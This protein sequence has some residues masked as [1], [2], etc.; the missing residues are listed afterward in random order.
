MLPLLLKA[1][2]ATGP[3]I[4]APDLSLATVPVGYFG[5]SA[6]HRDQANIEMLAKMRLVMIEKWEGRCWQDCLAQGPGS[7]PCQPACN[8]EADIIDT[9]KRIKAVNPRTAT[10]MYLNTLLAF[11]FYSLIG[12]YEAAGN[13]TIIP[14]LSV[15]NATKA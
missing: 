9:M 15:E 12:K 13:L 6:A 7:P 3:A 11:P 2:V 4:I 5:G 1:L 8:A 10:V 14:E